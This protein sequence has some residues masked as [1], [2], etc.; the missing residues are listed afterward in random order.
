MLSLYIWI[1][2]VIILSLDRSIATN[3]SD[4]Y[5][6]TTGAMTKDSTSNELSGVQNS[7]SLQINPPPNTPGI[8]DPWMIKTVSALTNA[9][10]TTHIDAFLSRW[11]TID[12]FQMLTDDQLHEVGL[13]TREILIFRNEFGEEAVAQRNTLETTQ[14]LIDSMST[15]YF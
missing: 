1:T 9:N 11:M 15:L 13:S 8:E 4:S 3:R 14:H 5:D 6:S 2:L 10:L 7:P 12:R